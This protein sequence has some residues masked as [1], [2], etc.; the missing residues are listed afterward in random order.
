M[1]SI[2]SFATAHWEYGSPEL[3]RFNGVSAVDINGE[4]APGVS[5][6]DAMQEIEELVAQLPPGFRIDWTG[7]VVPGARR[8]RADADRSTRCR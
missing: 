7:A 3:D 4:A 2:S 6:G 8:R 5:S 1:V